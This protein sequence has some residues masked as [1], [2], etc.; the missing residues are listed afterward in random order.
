MLCFKPGAKACLERCFNIIK[1]FFSTGATVYFKFALF[2][3]EFYAVEEYLVFIIP[4]ESEICFHI[5][6]HSF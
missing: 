2:Q 1:G 4:R 5:C 6:D 3:D